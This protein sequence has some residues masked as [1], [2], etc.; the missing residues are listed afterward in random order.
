MDFDQNEGE[1]K[2][3]RETNER[4]NNKTIR[5]AEWHFV[6]LSIFIISNRIK[7]TI[8]SFLLGDRSMA[9]YSMTS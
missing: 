4:Y 5:M 7:P 3:E 6:K 1:K 9:K 2:R 8:H